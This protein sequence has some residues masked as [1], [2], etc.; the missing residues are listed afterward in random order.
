VAAAAEFIQRWPIRR[1]AA[2]L[3]RTWMWVRWTAEVDGPILCGNDRRTVF[4]GRAARRPNGLMLATNLAVLVALK[5]RT[6]GRL[7]DV[8]FLFL[9]TDDYSKGRNYAHNSVGVSLIREYFWTRSRLAGGF[10]GLYI[11]L[12]ECWGCWKGGKVKYCLRV[13]GVREKVPVM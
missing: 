1:S 3:L 4:D 13:R 12:R 8:I 7:A 11:L 9:A 10:G 6:R 2:S 5:R